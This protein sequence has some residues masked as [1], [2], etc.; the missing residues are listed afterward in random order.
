M[1]SPEWEKACLGVRSSF[2]YSIARD[3]QLK[4][5]GLLRLGKDIAPPRTLAAVDAAY[6]GQGSTFGVA[7]ALVVDVT[8]RSVECYYAYG[9]V[10]IPYVP[11]LLAFRELELMTPA[12][13]KAT[14]GRG[15]DLLLVD[16]HGIAHPRGFG[17][18]S[19][20]G[21]ALRL[22]SVGVAKGLLYGREVPCDYG[23]CIYIGDAAVGAV[24][25]APTGSRIYVSPGNLVGL[26]YSVDV[27]RSL[28][29]D[30]LRLPY[31]LQA[32]D[33][34]SKDLRSMLR[35]KEPPE[36]KVKACDL[37]EITA[38]KN[39]AEV[40]RRASLNPRGTPPL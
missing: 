34:I 15:V 14:S 19:H 28:L 35:G 21:V 16:G 31:P 30:G 8:S 22:P 20:L 32:A 18:A 11:G 23:T 36:V 3:D 12:L 29:V 37:K 25:R 24:L 7:A 17:I 26:K 40:A 27:V 1:R 6:W 13:I 9:P 2:S 33:A 4:L 5:K 10:C 39:F 38:F